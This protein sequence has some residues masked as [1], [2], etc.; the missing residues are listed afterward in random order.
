MSLLA[1]LFNRDR[2]WR[3]R[4][5]IVAL[6][7]LLL[8]RAALPEVLRRVMIAQA[9]KILRAQVAIG[10][11][12]LALY[13]GGIALKDVAVRAAVAAA[14]DADT[15]PP[16]IGWKRL[17]IELRWLP[18]FRK[19]I[20]LQHVLL[21][22]P[23]LAVDR[24]ANGELNLLALLPASTETPPSTGPTPAATPAPAA[25]TWGFGVDRVIL[26][27]GGLRF[28]DLTLKDSEPVELNLEHVEVSDIALNQGVYGAPSTLHVAIAF[29]QGS[30]DLDARVA[31]RDD[32]TSIAASLN[33]WGLPLRQTRLYIPAVGWSAF[34]GTLDAALTY[35][36]NT[37]RQN[38]ISGTVAL[39]D[40]SVQV[41]GLDRPALAWRNLTIRVD[42][43][44]LI[45]QR[46]AVTDVELS[47]ASMLVRLQGGALLPLLA[48]SVHDAAADAVSPTPAGTTP[49]NVAPTD[50]PQTEGPPPESAAVEPP[51]AEPRPTA[52]ATTTATPTTEITST[53]TTEATPTGTLESTPGKAETPRAEP[54]GA[55]S[56]SAAAAESKP[57]TW[58]V[59]TLRIDDSAVH[60]LGRE[61]PLDLGLGLNASDIAGDVDSPAHV[62]LAVTVGDGSV[63]VDGGLRLQRPGFA[64]TIRIANLSLPQIL[65]S[66]T[67]LPVE[68]M[69]SGHLSTDLTVEA[70]MAVPDGDTLAPR[71]ARVH[72]HIAI[73]DA[74]MTTPA[75]PP[76]SIGARSVDLELKDLHVAGVLPGEHAP[77]AAD[78][79]SASGQPSSAAPDD[80]REGSTQTPPGAGPGRGKLASGDVHFDGTLSLAD[81]SVASADGKGLSA[82]ARS[83]ELTLADVTAGGVLPAAPGAPTRGDVQGSIHLALADAHAAPTGPQGVAVELQTFD[84]GI[85]ELSAQGILAQAPT[86]ASDVRFHNGRASLTDLKLTSADP[87]AL[88]V[89]ARSFELTL[90]DLTAGGVLATAPGVPTRGDLHAG[91]HL[92]VG[93]VHAAAEQP[94]RISMDAQSIEMAIA[95]VMARGLMTTAPATDVQLRDGRVSLAQLKLGSPGFSMD[96]QGI[97]VGIAELSAQPAAAPAPDV[98]LRNGRVS[99]AQFKLAGSDPKVFL[100]GTRSFDLPITDLSVPGSPQQPVR[101][102]VG[103][104]RLAGP[105]ALLT[106]T[107]DGLLLPQFSPASTSEPAAAQAPAPAPPPQGSQAQAPPRP[108]EV[109]LSSFRLTDGQV[110]TLD[111]S[112]KPFFKGGLAPLNIDVRGLRWPP[113]S[114]DKIQLSA[115]G[116]EN[117]TLEMYGALNP[118]EG[119]FEVYGDK[120]ALPPYNP[121]ATSFSAYSIGSGA[122]SLVTKGSRKQGRYYASTAL[123]LHDLNLQSGTGDSLFQQQFG[124]PLEMALALMRDFNGNITLDI[125]IEA[126][127]QGTKIDVMSVVAGALRHAIVNALTSPLKLVG[128]VFSGKEGAVAA[129][130]PIGFRPGRAE[131]DASGSQQVDQLAAFMANRPGIGV[132]LETSVTNTDVR[133]LREQALLKTWD[134]AGVLGTLRGL[135]QRSARDR[136][137]QAIA[138]RAKDEPAEL[139][140]EDSAA[141]DAW[142]NE[143][144]AIPAEQLTAL[145]NERLAH[146]ESALEEGHGLDATRVKRKEPAADLTDAAPAVRVEIGSVAR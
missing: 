131:L 87:K 90:S 43:V 111:R 98:Q 85:T 69:R 97:D 45:A 88:H 86:A 133:W 142:L 6:T 118:D 25:R 37:G 82:G 84:L 3:R 27:D 4:R 130:A 137:R 123:T 16:L 124:V 110:T 50:T 10:D 18:L 143:Q 17:D 20:R 14:G 12:D 94:Q 35:R 146:T 116:P 26:S 92:A 49:T 114:I 58:S 101:V 72:G 100:V 126:D 119:W 38:E 112:V 76:L 5:W 2:V 30:V 129:P 8:L 125:P 93:D 108:V 78:T 19:T 31:L 135:T 91:V 80:Q 40:L 102:T 121:Y 107:T 21:D 144:P 145:A 9:T 83:I 34:D 51:P 36:A 66:A 67:T 63:N 77:A 7:V 115:T 61:A 64:G 140:A 47:G 42:P 68:L 73:A 104:V 44:D 113:L 109:I 75:V 46:V 55:E 95:D 15:A 99:I 134:N 23:R 106:R 11:V 71:D 22:S 70:G 48:A 103:D 32:G 136:V 96:T 29:D 79:A 1:R 39:R 138:A 28:R 89:G 41:P 128:A 57:W 120:L 56:Q 141:L 127:S 24:L 60:L 139:S 81:P 65:I 13:R 132:T 105:T 59:A 54:Q 122:L 53:P 52:T 74:Q 62:A 33:A 117:G